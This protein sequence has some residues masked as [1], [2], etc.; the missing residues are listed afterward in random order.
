MGT[1]RRQGPRL[2][3]W[4]E[5]D[6]KDGRRVLFQTEIKSW[7]AWAIGG[8]TLPINAPAKVLSNYK[9][10]YW[11]GQWDSRRR[12]FKSPNVAKVLVP[13]KPPFDQDDREILPLIIYWAPAGPRRSG[14]KQNQSQGGHLFSISEPTCEFKFDVPRSWPEERGFEE[15]WVFSV[16]SY[17]RSL[18]TA[19]V[20]LPMPNVAARFAI[21]AHMMQLPVAENDGRRAPCPKTLDE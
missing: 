14:F 4:I 12:T 19:S 21:L 5:A 18:R 10:T 2:D 16:S 20:D 8:K 11:K 7:S 9:D 17:L 3:R 13:M 15:L 1:G 6:L